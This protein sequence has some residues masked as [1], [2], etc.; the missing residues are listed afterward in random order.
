MHLGVVGAW[1]LHTLGD[2][3][4]VGVAVRLGEEAFCLDRLC[5]LAVVG[6][7][8]LEHTVACKEEAG[9][10][11]RVRRLSAV[12]LATADDFGIVLVRHNLVVHVLVDNCPLLA[13]IDLRA[14]LEV[15][16]FEV[17]G[18]ATRRPRALFGDGRQVHHRAVRVGAVRRA[19]EDA[20]AHRLAVA[21]AAV[22]RL[23]VVRL[24]AW[25]GV[26]DRHRRAVVAKER[27][28]KRGEV[29][30]HAA[31][32][33]EL[34]GLRFDEE[35]QLRAAGRRK[36]I[37]QPVDGL[38]LCQAPRRLLLV[39]PAAML[40]ERAKLVEFFAVDL[41]D[42]LELV[43]WWQ[44]E[45]YARN[46][47][48]LGAEWLEAKRAAAHVEVQHLRAR[49]DGHRPRRV[50]GASKLLAPHCWQ[51]VTDALEELGG[52]VLVVDV[53]LK[54][55]HAMQQHRLADAVEAV[56]VAPALVE[57]FNRVVHFFARR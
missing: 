45:T 29:V 51:H 34:V 38:G 53:S 3:I 54:L 18:R 9:E 24:L 56:A 35:P 25:T 40:G 15:D 26:D 17:R 43:A 8:A 22:T 21:L 2:L 37:A 36:G 50:D 46:V 57:K 31:G 33:F 28:R 5:P 48:V 16:V 27:T 10:Y 47:P 32:P 7:E 39:R 11:H 13:L 19:V 52:G 14:P 41:A 42:V 44:R 6:K 20:L 1:A 55:A 12:E 30:N 4:V 49:V 23:C